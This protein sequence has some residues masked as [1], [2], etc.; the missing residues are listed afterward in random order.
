MTSVGGY[1][2]D[3]YGDPRM[4]LD[5]TIFYECLNKM[6]E[7]LKK[8]GISVEHADLIVLAISIYEKENK[9]GITTIDVECEKNFR[10]GKKIQVLR[11]NAMD[12]EYLAYLYSLAINKIGV[13][14]IFDFKK[15]SEEWEKWAE[16]GLKIL[17]CK[18]FIQYYTTNP[19]K[20]FDRILELA[21][22]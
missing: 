19:T 14:N 5:E 3:H 7:E 9:N 21:G 20:F 15:I 13:K 12:D 16:E 17:Y 4:S 8:D 6:E 10:K 22:Y 11:Y 18:Y 2:R 1:I